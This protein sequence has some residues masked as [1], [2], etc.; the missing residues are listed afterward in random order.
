[1]QIDNIELAYDLAVTEEEHREMKNFITEAL[2]ANVELRRKLHL[3]H[4]HH[5]NYKEWLELLLQVMMNAKKLE[6]YNPDKH[7]YRMQD[8]SDVCEE[9][10]SER[11]MI[12]ESKSWGK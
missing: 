11:F 6:I 5:N 10:L 3:C 1:M 8:W 12:R 7:S 2:R 4:V 9:I